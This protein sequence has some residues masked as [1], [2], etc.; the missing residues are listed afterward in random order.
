MAERM[1]CCTAL[2]CIAAAFIAGRL[3]KS[4]LLV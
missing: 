4:S 3:R 2:Y 1:P